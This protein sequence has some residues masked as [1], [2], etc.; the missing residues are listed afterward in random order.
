MLFEM[1]AGELPF[2]GDTSASLMYK[3]L[4]ESS[5]SL[6]GLRSGL[7]EA[8]EAVIQKALAKEPAQRYV[9]ARELADAFKAA[10][11]GETVQPIRVRSAKAK[12]S[13]ARALRL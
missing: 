8:V 11:L 12:P 5:P 2:I 10:L 4:S 9:S 6:R 13:T 1:L 7:P 3:H